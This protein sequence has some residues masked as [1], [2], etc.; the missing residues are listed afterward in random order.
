MV[1]QCLSDIL[2]YR[3]SRIYSKPHE[4]YTNIQNAH[5]QFNDNVYNGLLSES[6]ET[7]GAIRGLVIG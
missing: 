2:T 5:T 4:I 3:D 7:H 1:H 6:Y